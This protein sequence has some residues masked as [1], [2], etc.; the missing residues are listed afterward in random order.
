MFPVQ[1]TVKETELKLSKVIQWFITFEHANYV[2][3]DITGECNV[4]CITI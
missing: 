1:H 3:E 4:L 2:L